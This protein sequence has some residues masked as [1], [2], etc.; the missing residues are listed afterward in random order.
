MS[1]RRALSPVGRETLHDRVYAELRR[2]LIHGMFDAGEVLRIVEL[3]ETL[4]T[5]TMPVREALGRLVSEQALEALPNRSVRVPLITRERLDD[6]AR[7]RCLIEG[8]VTALAL[9]NLSTEDFARL[10]QLT[11]ACEEA[12][13]S[14]DPDKAHRT[15]ELNHDFH[16]AI[17]RA[18]GS[19]VLIP[20]VESL[21]LQSGPYV[22]AAAQIHDE[23]RDIPAT[24]YHWELI[25]A[26]ERGDAGEATRALTSDITRSFRLIR[27]RLD[28]EDAEER[29]YG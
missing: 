4:R 21:W 5:S 24:H 28:V 25:E 19:A 6:L 22:R 16:F 12:F 26:L 2:S 18:A 11:V 17:Y 13:R 15:S 10:R 29:A 27:G 14:D 20:I 7:A 1:R 23:Q 9:P 8:Q 3:A